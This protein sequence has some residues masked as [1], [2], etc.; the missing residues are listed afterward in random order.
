MRDLVDIRNIDKAKLLAGLYNRAKFGKIVDQFC[1]PKGGMSVQQAREIIA[2]LGLVFD[3]L[4][5]QALKVN[6]AGERFDSWGFN[7][8]RRPQAA[9]TVVATLRYHWER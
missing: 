7:W 5:D 4:G 8:N 1:L 9:Q 6:I 3:Y 2:E